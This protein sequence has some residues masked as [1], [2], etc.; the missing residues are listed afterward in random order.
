MLCLGRGC[1]GVGV[2]PL[3]GGFSSKVYL[4]HLSKILL[5]EAHFLLPPSSCQLG[6]SPGLFLFKI[7]C[8]KLSGPHS[9]N[10]IYDRAFI[11]SS[12]LSMGPTNFG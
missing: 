6:L 5:W 11:S 8:K 9:E 4:Q 12:S 2:L 1:G 3:L 10:L 7:K